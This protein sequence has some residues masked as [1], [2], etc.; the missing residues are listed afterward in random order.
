MQITKLKIRNFR[1]IKKLDIE[2]GDTT[3]L[4][5]QNN[6]GKSAILDAVRI[7][8]TR[9]WGQRGTGFTENDVYRPD[10]GGD[11]KTLPPV[12]IELMMEEPRAGAWDADL[13]AA[14]EDIIALA[15]DGRNLVA[16]RVTCSW[17]EE[18]ESFEPAWEFLDAAGLPMTG[19]AQRATNLTGFFGY[20]PCF[21]LAHSATHQTNSLRAQAIGADCSAA[22]E[23]LT[24]WKQTRSAFL[25]NSMQELWRPTL[26]WR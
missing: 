21:G 3:V 17:S 15:S 6:A 24:I 8:L 13:V 11:P 4:I 10:A 25:R 7:V 1:S 19:K 20:I 26:N 16:L 9:R 18:K 12:T 2:L 22:L 5:G 14:L 23:F